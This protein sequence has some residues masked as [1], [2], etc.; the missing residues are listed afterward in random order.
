[1]SLKSLLLI[2]MVLISGIPAYLISTYHK[3]YH[4]NGKLKSEGWFTEKGK[5]G[6]WKFYHKNG[7]LSGQ[8]HY[9]LDQ[10]ENYWHFYDTY[11]KLEKEGHYHNGKKANWWLFYDENGKINHKCQLSNSKKNGYCLKYRNEKLSSA[12]KY[13]NGRKIKEWF[14]FRSFRSENKLS[15]LE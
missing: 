14:S 13:S 7:V 9:V 2:S 10:R 4:E 3:D 6:Y 12:E 1:M 8:G 11:G 5:N 15:D